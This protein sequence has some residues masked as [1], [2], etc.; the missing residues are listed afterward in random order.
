MVLCAEAGALV[1]PAMPAFYQMP[2]TLDHLADFMAGKI[3][4]ALGFRHE[5]YPAWKG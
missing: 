3:L 5:L 1:M 2:Q 4:S